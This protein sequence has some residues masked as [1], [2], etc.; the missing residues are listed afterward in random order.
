MNDS[1]WLRLPD[2]SSLPLEPMHGSVVNC[3]RPVWYIS[4]VLLT[5]G[6]LA[7]VL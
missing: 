6:T 5:V 1:D 7:V 4:I 2:P 3:R